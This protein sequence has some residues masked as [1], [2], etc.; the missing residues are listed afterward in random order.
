MDVNDDADNDNNNMVT[1]ISI[2][3]IINNNKHNNHIWNNNTHP[4]EVTSFLHSTNQHYH[5]FGNHAV[6][7]PEEE[8]D[9]NGRPLIVLDGANIAYAY[10]DFLLEKE[11]NVKGIALAVNFFQS[12]GNV[13]VVLPSYFMNKKLLSKEYS[14]MQTDSLDILQS[15]KQ[16]HYL[17]LTPPAD[18]DDAYMIAIATSYQQKKYKSQQQPFN[19]AYIVSNDLFRDA[20]QRN[21]HANDVRQWLKSGNGRISYSFFNI[22]GNTID[23]DN[24]S[25]PKIEFI[26]NPRHSFIETI[27]QQQQQQQQSY[28]NFNF[29][30]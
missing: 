16:N 21:H 8:K 14:L 25:V 27:R 18:D 28:N 26:P 10:S 24:R 22:G 19:N 1:I 30:S 29:P 4:I 17:C 20:I 7:V 5:D 15:L 23:N 11:P 12:F 3:R 13:Q 9:W 6:V 2:Q